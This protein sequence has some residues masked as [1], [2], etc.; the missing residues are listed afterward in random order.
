MKRYTILIQFESGSES[1]STIGEYDAESATEA[2]QQVL[3]A[4]AGV[5]GITV[6]SCRELPEE[7]TWDDVFLG[8]QSL[9]SPHVRPETDDFRKLFNDVKKL[10]ERLEGRESE[11]VG[12]LPTDTADLL[13]AASAVWKFHTK[14]CEALGIPVSY[15]P[16]DVYTSMKEKLGEQSYGPY[17][18]FVETFERITDHLSQGFDD[19]GTDSESIVSEVERLVEA[20]EALGKIYGFIDEFVPDHG[21]FDTERLI[22]E[23]RKTNVDGPEKRFYLPVE[24]AFTEGSSHGT[25]V[26]DKESV[27]RVCSDDRE[28][29]ELVSTRRLYVSDLQ[30]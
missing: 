19:I 22:R 8:I 16:E 4:N 11:V 23:I 10:R 3:A 20:R 1:H 21:S 13:E 12:L 29:I 28:L 15:N 6:Q 14:T 18:E 17:A 7:V 27:R 25:V 5:V 26:L 24:F 2:M 9:S 30:E